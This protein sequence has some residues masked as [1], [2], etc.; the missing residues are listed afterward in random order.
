LGKAHGDGGFAGAWLA[1]E[2]DGTPT[3]LLFE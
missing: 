1:G 3:D 2:E